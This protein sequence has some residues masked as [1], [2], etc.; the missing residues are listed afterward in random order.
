MVS[1]GLKIKIWLIWAEVYIDDLGWVWI[2][3]KYVSVAKGVV[4]L[5]EY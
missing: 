1:H 2:D 4:Y 3:E 5:K